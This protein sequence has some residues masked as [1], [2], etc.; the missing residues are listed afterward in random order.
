[1]KY[2]ANTSN[3]QIKHCVYILPFAKVLKNPN[4]INSINII[5]CRKGSGILCSE[6]ESESVVAG[7][8]DNIL[9]QVWVNQRPPII[10]V[11]FIAG[12]FRLIHNRPFQ[13]YSQ[14]VI[15]VLFIAGTSVLFIAGHFKFIHSGHVR[16]IH[17]R[18]FQFYPQPAILV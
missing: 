8:L 9:D 15:S 17:S 18:P 14:P 11:L 4:I 16:F 5:I 6:H 3:S 10:L 1:M 12:Y 13:F 7:I 2:F